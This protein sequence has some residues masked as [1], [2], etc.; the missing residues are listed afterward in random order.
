MGVDRTAHGGLH[1]SCRGRLVVPGAS[2]AA[3]VK[4]LVEFGSDTWEMSGKLVEARRGQQGMA[5][6]ALTRAFVRHA[7]VTNSL[8]QEWDIET[9]SC[10]LYSTI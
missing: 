4:V 5:Q 9:Q 10:P 1:A 3:E 7:L 6:T 8:R 2:V